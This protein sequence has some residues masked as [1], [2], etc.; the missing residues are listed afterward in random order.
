M[1]AIELAQTRRLLLAKQLLTETRLPLVH[2]AYSSGFESV[3]RFNALFRSRYRLTPSTMRRASGAG[4]ASHSLR[5]T[6][7][8]RPPYAWA[9]LCR[10]LA[11]RAIAGVEHVQSDVYLRTVAVGQRRGWLRAEPIK[12]ERRFRWNST[13]RWPP[14]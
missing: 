13:R 6:L 1:T 12:G 11:A 10:F 4:P 14:R 7:A 3:R 8:Y 9:S 2:V 5:L